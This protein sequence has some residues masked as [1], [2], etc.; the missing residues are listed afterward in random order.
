MEP[1]QFAFDNKYGYRVERNGFERRNQGFE[2]LGQF[3]VAAGR[4]CDVEYELSA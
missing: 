2:H 3:E 4:F 1:Y